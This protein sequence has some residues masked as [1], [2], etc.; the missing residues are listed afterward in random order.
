MGAKRR[1]SGRCRGV[2]A[3]RALRHHRAFACQWRD[4]DYELESTSMSV[5]FGF[6]SMRLHASP[7]LERNVGDATKDGAWRALVLVPPADRINRSCRAFPSRFS[8]NP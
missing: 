2:S 4:A 8:R 6:M 5:S 3:V 1:Q 7:G